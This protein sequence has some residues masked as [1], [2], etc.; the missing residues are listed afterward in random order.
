MLTRHPADTLQWVLPAGDLK[1]GD[2][3]LA[4]IYGSPDRRL[5]SQVMPCK[6]MG[7]HKPLQRNVMPCSSYFWLSR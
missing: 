7:I 4:R 1:L 6:Y 5:T 3:G 2:F